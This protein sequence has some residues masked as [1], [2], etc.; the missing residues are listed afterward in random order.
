MT[1]N[2]LWISFIFTFNESSGDQSVQ[3]QNKLYKSLLAAFRAPCHLGITW[4]AAAMTESIVSQS[5]SVAVVDWCFHQY[6]TSLSSS[7]RVHETSRAD[8]APLTVLPFTLLSWKTKGKKYRNSDLRPP[9]HPPTPL[10]SICFWMY[11]KSWEFGKEVCR[12][13]ERERWGRKKREQNKSFNY[14]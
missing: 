4:D 5:G 14:K 10:P 3:G 11:L 8:R 6:G 7:G 1:E 12:E 2:I 9:Y 13:R